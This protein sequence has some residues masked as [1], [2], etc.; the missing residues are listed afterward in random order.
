[1]KKILFIALF[2]W[3]GGASVSATELQLTLR[4]PSQSGEYHNP[5]VAVWLE[6]SSGKSVKTLVLWREGAKWL[7]D[8]RRWWRKV[9]RKDSQLVDA[10][11]S[12][13]RAAG[14]YKLTFDALDD[15]N[16]SLPFG[17]YVLNIE[18]VRENGGRSMIKQKFTLNGENQT[19]KLVPSSELAT[20]TFTIK[21]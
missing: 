9:G 11:T 16:N 2:L 4:L 20:S 14:R 7:K 21:E 1:M 5:Y 8:M 13:T 3:L 12:A 10:V 17:N 18:V 15:N 19:F 6:N